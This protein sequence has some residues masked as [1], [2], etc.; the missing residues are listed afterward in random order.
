[1]KNPLNEFSLV[2]NY[3]R[4]IGWRALPDL[5]GADQRI[6]IWSIWA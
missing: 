5:S 6:G 2:R 3:A 4:S 1:M